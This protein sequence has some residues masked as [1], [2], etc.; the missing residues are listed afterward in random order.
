MMSLKINFLEKKIDIKLKGARIVFPTPDNR[1]Y[2]KVLID[3][4]K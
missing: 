1:R 3:E 4:Q 2:K